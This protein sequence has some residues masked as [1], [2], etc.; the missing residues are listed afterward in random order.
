MAQIF[1]RDLNSRVFGEISKLSSEDRVHKI[2]LNPLPLVKMEIDRDRVPLVVL[3]PIVESQNALK[4]LRYF[5]NSRVIWMYRNYRDV[6]ASN[7][8]H[9]G[10]NNGKNDLQAIVRAAPQN[11][12][13]QNVPEYIRNIIIN[14]FSETM[15][16]YD[17]A[18]LF[19]LARNQLFFE[20][21]LDKHPDVMMCKYEELVKNAAEVMGEI[22]RFVG[23]EY[24]SDKILTAVR[25]DLTG[26]GES[27][28][29]SQEIDVLCHDLLEGLD[30]VY[31]SKFHP[32]VQ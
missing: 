30:T 24:P 23:C 16:P 7:I 11:W 22:Y 28:E 15:N 9:W 19:W 1:D 25:S 31:R 3:K 4:L 20:L 14:H 6:A 32:S 17:A 8:G 21:N 26:K 27:I 5:E 2:R 10:I 13:S 12:R 18:A 29:L